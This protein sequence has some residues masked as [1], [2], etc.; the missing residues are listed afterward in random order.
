M[1]IVFSMFINYC[2]E[3]DSNNPTISHLGCWEKEFYKKDN[4]EVIKEDLKLVNCFCRETS[5]EAELTRI[6]NSKK[7]EVILGY[8]KKYEWTIKNDKLYFGNIKSNLD[9]FLG[10]AS[11]LTGPYV[12]SDYNCS[13]KDFVD[14][15]LDEFVEMRGNIEIN[16]HKNGEIITNSIFE[17]EWEQLHGA[18]KYEIYIDDNLIHEINDNDENYYDIDVNKYNLKNGNHSFYI[19]AVN[20]F[21]YK[22][23][24]VINLKIDISS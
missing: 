15:K 4:P 12:K 11:D 2:N 17:L 8:I 1:L 14:A 20:D 10:S 22:S 7:H 18:E 16:S 23:S 24:P 5:K 13:D 6:I 9:S 21:Q 19:R 3:D